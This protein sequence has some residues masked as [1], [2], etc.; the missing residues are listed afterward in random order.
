MS[1][2]GNSIAVYTNKSKYINTDNYFMGMWN[3]DCVIEVIAF[4]IVIRY[5]N[6]HL[7]FKQHRSRCNSNRIIK[8]IHRIDS[9]YNRCLRLIELWKSK[10][11]VSLSASRKRYYERLILRSRATDCIKFIDKYVYGIGSITWTKANADGPK[12][13]IVLLYRKLIAYMRGGFERIQVND[14]GVIRLIPKSSLPIDGVRPLSYPSHSRKFSE[15]LLYGR[16][17]DDKLFHSSSWGFQINKN[18]RK[19]VDEIFSYFGSGYKLVWNADLSDAF[20]GMDRTWIRKCLI[21][22]GIDSR[23]VSLLMKCLEVKYKVNFDVEKLEISLGPGV[24]KL[25]T[26]KNEVSNLVKAELKKLR[27]RG[28]EIFNNE[29]CDVLNQFTFQYEGK[30]YYVKPKN[31][32]NET[33]TISWNCISLDEGTPQGGVNSP[34]LFNLGLEVLHRLIEDRFGNRVKLVRYADD[35]VLMSKDGRSLRQVKRFVKSFLDNKAKLKVNKTKSYFSKDS[36]KFLGYRIDA[37]GIYPDLKELLASSKNKVKPKIEKLVK[38]GLSSANKYNDA[39]KGFDKV[40]FIKYLIGISEDTEIVDS[41][42]SFSQT[43]MFD[44]RD[45]SDKKL[46]SIFTIEIDSSK[47]PPGYA[48]LCNCLVIFAEVLNGSLGLSA[49]ERLMDVLGV[50]RNYYDDSHNH[51]YCDTVL[52]GVLNYYLSGL[53]FKSKSIYSGSYSSFENITALKETDLEDSIKTLI[54]YRWRRNK[55][56]V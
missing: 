31:N 49:K 39:V 29:W 23:E 46:S 25:F 52:L 35:Y 18:T 50:A 34:M 56:I 12:M 3:F 13:S 21:S 19:C 33:D 10:Y 54:P 8:H 16:V 45:C 43:E 20:N 36:C 53:G 51:Y 5:I 14:R 27:R 41:N 26:I 42:N 11:E 1:D 17:Y 32:L 55:C 47:A 4:N 37:S 2:I 30:I 48:I 7:S 38:I 24:D 15:Y 44:Y 6:K 9:L 28:N 40:K 22:S